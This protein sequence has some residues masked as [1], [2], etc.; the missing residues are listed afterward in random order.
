M[1]EKILTVSIAAYNVEAYLEDTLNSCI[2]PLEMQKYLEVIVVNDGS[3]DN[4]WQIAKRYCDKYPDLFVCINKENGG[5]GSTINCSVKLAKGKY[6]RLLDGDDY[7]NTDELCNFIKALEN[8]DVDLI[9]N[10]YSICYENRK[11]VESRKLNL[12]EK[13][14]KNISELN[15]QNSIGMFSFCYKTEIL[16]EKD[17]YIDEKCLYTDIEFLVRPLRYIKNYTYLHNNL[18]QYRI[19][20]EGQSVSVEGMKHHYKDAKKVLYTVLSELRKQYEYNNIQNIVEI[21][22]SMMVKRVIKCMM[23]NEVSNK[24]RKRILLF[25]K[26]VK[27][28]F[29]EIYAYIDKSFLFYFLRRTQ[30]WMYPV[31][32]ALGK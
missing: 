7:F 10:D 12:E 14:S 5:Y 16:K 31:W 26:K 3:T 4:T 15:L 28:E 24:N 32:R 22:A 6:F 23:C 29:P 8:L 18:Y 19:G 2:V 17:I 1:G 9:L 21:V 30:Y 25:D 13:V 11:R 20:R 27:K